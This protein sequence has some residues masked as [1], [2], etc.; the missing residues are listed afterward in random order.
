MV[1]D[2]IEKLDKTPRWLKELKQLG[3]FFLLAALVLIP[4]KASSVVFFSVGVVSLVLVLS[5]LARKA[6]FPYLDMSTLFRIIYS[7]QDD[8]DE[9]IAAALVIL[10]VLG[11]YGIM[12]W[13]II[14][15]LK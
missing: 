13:A 12:I 4:D 8:H 6:L 11:L 5:H 2:Y 7:K 9:P 1:P 3:P 15:L 14:S 10:G